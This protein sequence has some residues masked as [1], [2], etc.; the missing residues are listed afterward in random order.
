MHNNNYIC[1][2]IH[3]IVHACTAGSFIF[4]FG[5]FISAAVAQ[6]LTALTIL[7]QVARIGDI[8]ART[9][10]FKFAENTRHNHFQAEL[11]LL[12]VIHVTVGAAPLSF[13]AYA[14]KCSEK[15]KR[16]YRIW[17]DV[18]LTLVAFLRFVIECVSACPL[19]I[20]VYTAKLSE[21]RIF[22]VFILYRLIQK[23]VLP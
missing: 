16:L 19:V 4:I 1:L 2:N 7:L 11:T 3:V 10:R 9:P 22:R 15:S 12:S 13:T 21:H 5:R 8:S 6:L 14:F 23:Q 20:A 18:R 17:L